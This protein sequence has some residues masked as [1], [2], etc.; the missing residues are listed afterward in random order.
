M[1]GHGGKRAGAGAKPKLSTQLMKCARALKK[2]TAG[3]ILAEIDEIQAW[4]RH[5][6]C[7]DNRVSLE[8]LKY[9]TDKRDGR[10]VQTVINDNRATDSSE[11]LAEILAA[12]TEK[13]HREPAELPEVGS[14]RVN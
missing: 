11:R 13:A 8:A 10:A 4:K 2:A 3:E 14:D 1:A 9:L 5:L 7:E 6:Q 12:A